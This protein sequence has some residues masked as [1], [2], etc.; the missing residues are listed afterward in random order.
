[1]VIDPIIKTQ[2]YTNNAYDKWHAYGILNIYLS[3]LLGDVS[4]NRI[5]TTYYITGVMMAHE[6]KYP[7]DSSVASESRY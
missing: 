5:R 2:S 1:M 4:Y 6:S 7:Q 3:Y